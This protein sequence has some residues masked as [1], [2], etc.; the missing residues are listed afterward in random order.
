V[1]DILKGLIKNCKVDSGNERSLAKL[2][3]EAEGTKR[4][5]SLGTWD[6]IPIESLADG[7]DLHS[8]INRLRYELSANVFDQI[9]SLVENVVKKEKLDPLDIGEVGPFIL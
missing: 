4:T 7:Y 8:T 2:R 5:L 3:L 9:V 6:T 1:D